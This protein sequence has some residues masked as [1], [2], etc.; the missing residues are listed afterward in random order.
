MRVTEIF[1]SI[2]GESSFAGMPCTFIRLTGCNLRCTWCDTEYSFYGGSEMSHGEILAEIEKVGC[3]I[4]EFTGGEPLLQRAVYALITELLDR[5]YTVLV[6]TGGSINLSNLDP[7]AIKVMDIKC[8]AS[9]M[10]DKMDFANIALLTGRDEVKFV[11][12]DRNDYDYAQ[13]IIEKY[14]LTSKT[15]LL[16]SPVYGN[17]DLKTLAEWILEDK[18]N[19]RFQ[20]QLHKYIWGPDVRGV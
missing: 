15:N 4:V 12:L 18:L 1:Y 3:K 14:D 8:P 10:Q 7:R 20:I 2:Q 9:G 6:E 16:F 11:I 5:E 13:N 17:L 19:A